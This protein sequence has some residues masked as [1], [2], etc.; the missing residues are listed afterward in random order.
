MLGNELKNSEF[1]GLV[2]AVQGNIFT[3]GKLDP[4]TGISGLLEWVKLHEKQTETVIHHLE[5]YSQ[6]L[7]SNT[8]EMVRNG[9]SVLW[10][11]FTPHKTTKPMIVDSAYKDKFTTDSGDKF[12]ASGSW[13]TQGIGHGDIELSR[14]ASYAAGRYGHVLF[15][16]IVHEPVYILSK[17]L[18][19]L[20]KWA[21][22]VF[23]T[24]NGSTALEVALKMAFKGKN[25]KLSVV[26]IEGSYHGDTIGAMD[27]SNPNLFNEE[28]HWYKGKGK[29][30]KKF[31][32]GMKNKKLYLFD[33]KHKIKDGIQFDTLEEVFD[34]E[35]DSTALASEYEALIKSNLDLWQTENELGAIVIE[36]VIH[37]ADGMHFIDPLF[38]RMLVREG[39]L[40][41]IPIIFDEI[42]VGCYRLGE[43]SVTK[44]LHCEPDI[45]C[46]SKMLSGGLLPLAAVLANEATFQKFEN[47]DTRSSLLHGHSYTA[48]PVGC[49]VALNAMER[50]EAMDKTSPWPNEIVSQI[51]CLENVTRCYSMGLVFCCEIDSDIRGYGSNAARIVCE[52]LFKAGIHC[53]P[54]GNVVYFMASYSTTKKEAEEI[55]LNLTKVLKAH[56]QTNRN[57]VLQ[58]KSASQ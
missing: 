47:R 10:W 36:P 37:G 25:G 48:Y 14:A 21:H 55:L 29:W 53:R 1:R 3:F 20:N 24:D 28:I 15:P 40:R 45:S 5:Q 4:S 23:Y 7:V 35:R 50:Y 38:Q 58:S 52:E 54:L 51:S 31:T 39:K 2:E 46:Y 41:R 32:V 17:H 11:P 44:L 22:R 9:E 19:K 18:L 42:F 6:S 12:D 13:W 27:I 43:P 8:Q 16:S 34:I 56:S 33:E 57:S 26:G 30:F 49:H